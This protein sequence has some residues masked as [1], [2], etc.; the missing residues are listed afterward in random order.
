MLAQ[1]LDVAELNWEDRV[2][3]DGVAEEKKGTHWL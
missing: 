3:M 2:T 1:P